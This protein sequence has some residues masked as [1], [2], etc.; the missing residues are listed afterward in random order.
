MT[1]DDTATIDEALEAAIEWHAVN[2]RA[3]LRVA[4][5]SDNYAD[6]SGEPALEV[7]AFRAAAELVARE[8]AEI[9]AHAHDWNERDY[10]RVCGADGRA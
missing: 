7:R 5:S 4:I 3:Q 10:C 6:I 8:A 1:P 9:A 2:L